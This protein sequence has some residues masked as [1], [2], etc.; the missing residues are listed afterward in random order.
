MEW[1]VKKGARKLL[2]NTIAQEAMQKGHTENQFM[3]LSCFQIRLHKRSFE[4][5]QGKIPPPSPIFFCSLAHVKWNLCKQENF[6]PIYLGVAENY[7]SDTV[8]IILAYQW[9]NWQNNFKC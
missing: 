9:N 1:Q 6:Q 4:E 5:V 3:M 7:F 2:E 8:E